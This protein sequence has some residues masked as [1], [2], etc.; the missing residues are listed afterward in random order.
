[1]EPETYQCHSGAH[2]EAGDIV[3]TPVRRSCGVT[4]RKRGKVVA[5][6]GREHPIRGGREHPRWSGE[7]VYDG[8]VGE[9]AHAGTTS[10]AVWE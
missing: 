6:G 2:R 9:G 1:M 8:W 4:T 7:D 3:K 10:P 5:L